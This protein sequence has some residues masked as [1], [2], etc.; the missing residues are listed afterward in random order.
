MLSIFFIG[1]ALS[2]DAF[3]VAINLGMQK[4]SKFKLFLIPSLIAIFHFF[5][6]LMGV[7][8]GDLLV[9]LLDFNPKII[10]VIVFLYLIIT[11]ILERKKEKKVIITNVISILLL[12]LSVSIDSF[13]VG[14]GLLSITEKYLASSLMFSICAGF[15]TY[16]G[17]LL[18]KYSVK[19][20]KDKAYILGITLLGIMTI[21]N[22]CQIIFN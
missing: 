18:G 13:T 19:F 5:M 3:S 16:I 6:P 20:L 12:A 1:I 2:M 15:I 7:K 4:L 9:N 11:F 22:I 10:M 8:C 21:V 17:L 14:L